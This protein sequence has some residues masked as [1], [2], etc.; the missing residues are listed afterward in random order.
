VGLTLLEAV[1]Y[2]LPLQRGIDINFNIGDFQE[3]LAE[4]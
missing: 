4:F 3:A 2:R 1:G